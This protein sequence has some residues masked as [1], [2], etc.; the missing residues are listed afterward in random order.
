MKI[1][2][3]K[4][5]SAVRLP[6]LWMVGIE[7]VFRCRVCGMKFC[8][9]YKAGAVLFALGLVMSVATVNIL[10]YLIGSRSMMVLFYL[11]FPLWILYGALFRRWWLAGRARKKLQDAE[12][13]RV[14]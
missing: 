5:G 12:K 13:R 7:S 4:C 9:G 10:C 14:Q 8:T 11:A 2:C 6:F 3:P 1:K